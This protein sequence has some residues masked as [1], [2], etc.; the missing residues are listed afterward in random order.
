MGRKRIED[1]FPDILPLLG[2]MTD[3]ELA[4]KYECVPHTIFGARKRH[5]IPPCRNGGENG[6]GMVGVLEFPITEEVAERV[7]EKAAAKVTEA[8]ISKAEAKAAKVEAKAAKAEAKAAK[9]EA[10]AAVDVVSVEMTM[11]E[12]DTLAQPDT[13]PSASATPAP[14]E[15]I[16]LAEAAAAVPVKNV[17]R[18]ERK[19]ILRK[20]SEKRKSQDDT[21]GLVFLV[22]AK[23]EGKGHGIKCYP[24]QSLNG[25]KVFGEDDPRLQGIPSS[26]AT[27]ENAQ[28]HLRATSSHSCKVAV[29]AGVKEWGRTAFDWPTSQEDCY[30]NARQKIQKAFKTNSGLELEAGEVQALFGRMLM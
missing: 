28:E 3:K 8:P 21:S 30:R 11:D 16:V 23:D 20:G 13:L 29:R 9:A 19:T 14:D 18:D 5:N 12:L 1:K 10:K 17:D 4:D 15:I 6:S 26:F 7:A 2:T 22:M 27:L 25:I 24:F